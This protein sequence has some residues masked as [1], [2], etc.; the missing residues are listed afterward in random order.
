MAGEPG[1]PELLE[2]IYATGEVEDEDGVRV[3]AAP[4]GLARV[5]A[6]ALADLVGE[7]RLERTL[8]V[9]LAYGLSALAITSVHARRGSGRH[10]A[11]DPYAST[12]YRSIA[13]TNLRRAGLDDRVDVIEEGSETALPRLA[14]QRPQSIDLVLIDG[15]HH[16]DTTLLDLFYADRLLVD[17]GYVAVDDAE[18]ASVERALAYVLS[19]RAYEAVSPRGGGLMVL[20][21]LH[22]D[23]RDWDHH[24]PFE[25]LRL[26]ALA[27]DATPRRHGQ[28]QLSPAAARSASLSFCVTTRGPAERVRAQLE[29]LRPHV[30]EVVLAVNR[31]GGLDTLDAC[32]DLADRR[33]TY[34]FSDSPSR[35]IAWVLHQCSADWILRLDDDEVP[36]AE[37][38]RALPGM[39]RDRRPLE[40]MIK[41]RWLHPDSGRMIAAPAPWNAEYQSRIVRNLPGVW[42][43]DGRVHTD[44]R[45]EGERRLVEAPIYHCALLLNP[46]EDRRRRALDYEVLRPG[47]A[48]GGL[49]TNGMYLPELVEGIETEAVPAEDRE[50]VD[51]VLAGS[52]ARAPRGA[53]A[54]AHASLGQIDAFNST[55]AMGPSAYRARLE[56][57]SAPDRMAVD[58]ERH[59]ELR[60]SNLGDRAWPAGSVEPLIRIGY[61]WRDVD[62]DRVVMDGRSVFWETVEPGSTALTLIAVRTPDEAGTYELE[63]DVLHEHVRWFDCV[64]T[65]R[66]RIDP[67][68][69]D[70]LVGSRQLPGD[71][72]EDQ[73]R[74]EGT[75]LGAQLRASRAAE[76][77]ANADLEA[78]RAQRRWKAARWLARPLDAT[79]RRR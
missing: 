7:A 26:D 20:R 60:V 74:D 17:G 76:E 77:R 29:L 53:E 35:L 47:V 79:R 43:F 42:R 10:I 56:F 51:R 63:V 36:S 6:L 46:F 27:G 23:D 64:A 21:K 15:R 62:R 44:V 5:D 65:L 3:A 49:P 50:L 8:E 18:Y 4:A 40:L 41:R 39:L 32:A 13:H 28:H 1:L 25:A 2:R 11:I 34:E 69:E 33:L 61:R 55:R 71:T 70:L 45:V 24:V 38:L 9:G 52:G 30:D 57:V 31:D 14:A 75:R 48:Y 54:E 37:L 66:V 12:T 16:F 68:P 58:T 22:G 72:F 78:L 19:N 67:D 73:L 59:L